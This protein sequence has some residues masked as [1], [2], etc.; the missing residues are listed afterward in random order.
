MSYI[1]WV[2]LCLSVLM[3]ALPAWAVE[4]NL[5]IVGG[6]EATIREFL[7]VFMRDTSPP[8]T[9]MMIY[10]GQLPDELPVEIPMPDGE[11]IGSIVREGP[12][13]TTEMI[14]V[15]TDS[16]E[17]IDQFFET[18][19]ET[20]GWERMGLNYGQRGFVAQEFAYADYCGQEKDKYVNVN[21]R[22]IG[23]ETQVRVAINMA[24][25]YM[26]NQGDMEAMQSQDPYLRLPKLTTPEGVTMLMNRGGG[27]GGGGYPGNLYSAT[28]TWLTS[29]ILTISEL[30]DEYDAQLVDNGWEMI[31]TE[32]G[33]H[34]SLSL[35]TFEDNGNTWSGYFSLMESATESGQFYA[36]IMV[37]QVSE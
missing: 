32:S 34:T 6:D 22:Q 19:M 37:E 7:H 33:E 35:W 26:C 2:V 9:E 13:P 10:I 15:S 4:D 30:M 5:T 23:D 1:K 24:D 28:S 29:D 3:L 25:P 8:D 21:M 20:L 14:F 31:S 17:N 11:I 18:E 27:G 12:Y 16:V 36:T